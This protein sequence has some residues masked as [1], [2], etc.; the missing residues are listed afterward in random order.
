MKKLG[1]EKRRAEVLK[2]YSRFKSYVYYDNFNMALRSRLSAF[3]S[4]GKVEVKLQLLAKELYNYS[5]GEPLSERIEG[6]IKESSYVVVPKSFRE[7]D[8]SQRKSTLIFSNKTTETYIV[9]KQTYLFDGAIDLHLISTLWIM[10]EGI[11]LVDIIGKDSYGYHLHLTEDNKRFSTDK[12]LFSKYF[13][14]YQ[15]WR[16]KG[17]KVAK[18]QIEAGNDVLLVSL[19]IK[20]FFHSVKIDFNDLRSDIGI[21]QKFSFTHL[22]EKI[23]KH[24][25]VLI[26]KRTEDELPILPIALPSSGVIANW[27]L[28]TFDK[29]IKDKMAPIYYGRYVD[30]IFI[31]SSNITPPEDLKDHDGEKGSEKVIDWLID[32]FFNKGAPLKKKKTGKNVDLVFSDDKYG[33]LVIQPSKLRLF[34]FSPDWPLAMLNKFEKTIAEN[35]S[36]FWFLPEEENMKDSLD[37]DAYDMHYEDTIN[38]FR[39]ISDVKASKYGASV[40]LAKRIKLAILNSKVDGD[41]IPKQIFRFFN[42]IAI[43]SLYNLW[44]KVITYFVVTNDSE[45]LAKFLNKALVTLKSIDGSE[46]VKKRPVIDG[47]YLHFKSS[48]AMALTLNPKVLR[49]I[50]GIKWRKPDDYKEVRERTLNYRRSLLLRH[51]YL[52]LPSLIISDYLVNSEGSLLSKGLFKKLIRNNHLTLNHE[53][54]K[55]FWRIPRWLYFQEFCMYLMLKTLSDIDGNTTVFTAN[56]GSTNRELD[57][58]IVKIGLE[59]YSKYNGGK[60]IS[61]IVSATKYKAYVNT[62]KNDKDHIKIYS[63]EI[64]LV[65][66]GKFKNPTIGITN[67]K[68]F[69]HEVLEAISKESITGSEKRNRHMKILNAAEVEKVDL[70][71]LPE[72]SVPLEFLY[73]YSDEARRKNRAFIFGLEHFTLGNTCYNLTMT[74]LPFEIGG[75]TDV[76]ILP[77]IKNH[78]SPGEKWEIGRVNKVIPQFRPHIYHLFKWRGLQFT[79][80]NCYELTDVVQRSVFR[81]EL[82]ILFAIEYNKD[83]NYFSNIAES[84]TRDLHCFY[85]QAN[86]SDY[87]DSRVVLPKESM[88][89]NPVRVKGGDNNVILTTTLDIAGLRKFQSQPITHQRDSKEFKITPPDFDHESPKKRGK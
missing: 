77:R 62:D 56:L 68:L 63:N 32:R 39:S 47:L 86:S 64:K 73:A 14:K 29:A 52:P 85:V 59:L 74:I 42:G 19:D 82:D 46:E 57:E 8:S 4:D 58:I 71:I 49:D 17:I 81:S 5:R 87:G 27:F 37:D 21:N 18:E 13:E 80:Y 3:E 6:L 83:V 2:A 45:N 69:G 53:I 31:V 20:N 36:A 70:L 65:S 72:T 1:L 35:S 28:A 66:K 22:I 79:V 40:F 55:E 15:E 67:M 16:D 23:Y 51:H 26:G 76:L 41:D 75:M 7:S 50:E 30:D 10:E 44:E 54:K 84:A 11:S 9:E 43:L 78:Y 34:Y 38:K 12:L 48:L 89:M 88:L 33:G 25:S 61:N 24:Y 60:D